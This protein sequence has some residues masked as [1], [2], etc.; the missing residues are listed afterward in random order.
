MTGTVF[1]E[2]PLR[3]PEVLAERLNGERLLS[4]DSDTCCT[5]NLRSHIEDVRTSPYPESH[6]A[7]D[8]RSSRIAS[9][10]RS[11]PEVGYED[12]GQRHDIE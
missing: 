8:E 11:Y 1:G 2:D 5:C 12:W 7:E 3:W 4:A 6:H 10:P 9:D